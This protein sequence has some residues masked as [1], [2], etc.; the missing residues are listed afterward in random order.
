MGA[1]LRHREENITFRR[2]QKHQLNKLDKI[3]A[4]IEDEV[5]EALLKILRETKDEGKRM[6]AATKLM[7]LRIQ[8]SG[9]INTDEIQR[10]LLETKN[11]DRVRNLVPEDDDDVPQINFTDIVD[12]D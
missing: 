6:Q 5:V 10:L 9:I 11:P 1:N 4:D 7:D 3:L 2:K 8:V 12:A